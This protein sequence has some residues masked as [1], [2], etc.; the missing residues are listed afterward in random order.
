MISNLDHII[1]AVEN[2]E[3]STQAYALLLG[4]APSWRGEHPG[5]GSSN[6]IFRLANTY[7][8]LVAA[9]GDGVFADLI[10]A[11][12]SDKGE[13]LLG[14]AFGCLDLQNACKQLQANGIG[15]ADI[16]H[17]NA[18]SSN[19]ESRQWQ[20]ALLDTTSLNGLFAF[21]IEPE[22]TLALP[23]S[24]PLPDTNGRA[25]VDAIDHLVIE[26]HDAD[27]FN[28]RFSEQLGLKLLLDQTIEKWQ[29][30]QLFYRVGG[31]TLEVICKLKDKEDAAKND[32]LWGL[33]YRAP[34]I[35]KLQQRL[36]QSDIN[37]SELRVG[38]K[39]GTTVA[40]PKSHTLG[41]ASLFVGPEVNS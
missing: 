20:M 9:T 13:G 12:I 16:Q 33:A 5:L 3:D 22:D 14:V 35:S 18:Q 38:R 4:R 41:I 39:K 25:C 28:Q 1:I 11:H 17:A 8:E 37:V 31:V 21:L 6:S 27:I 23:L 10:T 36:L 32:L 26:T 40:T 15:V 7:L 24:K 30:R 2:L 34:D 19:G 29:V